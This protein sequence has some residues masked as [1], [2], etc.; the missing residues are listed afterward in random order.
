MPMVECQWSLIDG[1]VTIVEC[2][3]SLVK[4]QML[5]V[6]SRMSMVDGQWSNVVGRWSN[7]SDNK[8]LLAEGQMFL[9]IECRWSKVDG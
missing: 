1:Q 2:R 5:L 4:G 6:N 7:A 3:W 8:R 9:M